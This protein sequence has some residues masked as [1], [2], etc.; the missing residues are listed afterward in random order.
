[1]EVL[2]GAAPCFSFCCPILHGGHCERSERRTTGRR[3]YLLGWTAEREHI[4]AAIPP[5][6]SAEA[7]DALH[8]AGC[9]HPACA[10]SFPALKDGEYQ[11]LQNAISELRD[12]A[13]ELSANAAESRDPPEGKHEPFVV[14]TPG[15]VLFGY[16]DIDAAS[17]IDVDA[18][19][20]DSPIEG[21]GLIL[22]P[23]RRP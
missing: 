3:P 10:L 4:P 17:K 13:R 9:L 15:G 14:R 19:A 12:G 6:T 7:I 1:M 18:L 11:T 20:L 22:C 21:S 2:A 16:G 8:E 23:I 5:I